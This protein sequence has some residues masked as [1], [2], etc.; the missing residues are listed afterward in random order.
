MKSLVTSLFVLFSITLTNG[1]DMHYN[2][3]WIALTPGEQTLAFG[4]PQRSVFSD[5]RGTPYAEEQ[6]QE[7]IL[8]GPNDQV[9]SGKFRFNVFEQ[10]IQKQTETGVI[11]LLRREYF[12]TKIGNDLYVIESYEEKGKPRKG[13]FIEKNTGQ[14]R[15]LVQEQKELIPAKF[16]GW[17]YNPEKPARFKGSTRYF[18][19]IDNQSAFEVRLNE[20]EILRSLP[21]H[22]KEV[23]AFVKNRNLKMKTEKE[24]LQVLAYY[25]S[26]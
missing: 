6:F 7:G 2:Q 26:L 20:K 9:L 10:E 3:A 15:L 25:N 21:E 17:S 12:K 1:Q 13:Y 4:I 18:M 5:I 23:K 22:K 19:S 8:Y 14:V 24:V 16:P 11:T